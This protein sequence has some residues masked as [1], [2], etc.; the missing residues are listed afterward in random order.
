M[1]K[2]IL[3]LCAAAFIIASCKNEKKTDDAKKESASSETKK[4]ESTTSTEPKA[5]VD[6]ATMMKNWQDYMT[7][8][9]VHK[10]MAS[11]DGTW[12][13]EV[14]MWMYPGAP[15]Q[16]STSTAVNKMVFNGLYQQSTHTGDMMGMP[17]NGLST[18]AYD[19]HKKEFMS[20]WIDNMG[21]GIMLLK[22][23][24]DDATKSITL[25]G[26][27]TDPGTKADCDVR[28][29]FQIIDDKTQEMKMYITMPDEKEFNTMQIKYTRKK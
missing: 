8:G 16:K 7:P 11:W 14:T 6:S 26:K 13:G 9:D 4:D 19:I 29:T 18:V 21:S 24:W 10:M 20:T 28:E 2:I 12:T 17:F 3:T 1:K 15:E 22:G 5:E 27:M 25:K 23:P